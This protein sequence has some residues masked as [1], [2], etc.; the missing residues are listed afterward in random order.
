MGVLYEVIKKSGHYEVYIEDKFYCSA[1]D[2]DEAFKEL[3]SY[4]EG[5][6]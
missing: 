5:K 3:K 4:F 6:N 2:L 1:D